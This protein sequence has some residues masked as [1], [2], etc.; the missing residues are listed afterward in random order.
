MALPGFRGFLRLCV[1]GSV[2]NRVRSTYFRSRLDSAVKIR[3]GYVTPHYDNPSL[4]Y[5]SY[6]FNGCDNRGN[7]KNN[8]LDINLSNVKH[9][10][11][12][13]LMAEWPF[14]WSYSCGTKAVQS[15]ARRAF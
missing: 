14:H 5:G 1:I 8:L 15:L 2:R 10:T 4:D 6:V 7:P 13:R 11:R 9:P 3:Y 12:T